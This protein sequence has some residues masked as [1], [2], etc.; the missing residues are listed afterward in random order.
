M[1]MRPAVL[2]QFFKDTGTEKTKAKRTTLERV[3]TA[4]SS[5]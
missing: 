3:N 1:I 2:V 4:G 5:P